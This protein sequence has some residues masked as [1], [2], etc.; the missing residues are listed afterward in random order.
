[1]RPITR[2]GVSI[3]FGL[4][5]SADLTPCRYP[6]HRLSAPTASQ[7][8]ERATKPEAPSILYSGN[9]GVW[10]MNPSQKLGIERTRLCPTLERH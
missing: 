3:Q 1:M 8:D 2:I 9:E 5:F 10:R 6:L 4:E 7:F